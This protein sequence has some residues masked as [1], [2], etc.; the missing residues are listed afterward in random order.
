MSTKITF[1][2]FASLVREMRAAQDGY[3]R[4]KN[5]TQ[6]TKAKSLEYRVDQLARTIPRPPA[7]EQLTATAETLNL[8]K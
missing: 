8:F 4:Y 2:Q 1:E 7:D 5:K 3:F 6:L